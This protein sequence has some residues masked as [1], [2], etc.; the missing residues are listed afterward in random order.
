MVPELGLIILIFAAI[1][2]LSGVIMGFASRSG[3]IVSKHVIAVAL[4]I[5]AAMM[6][7]ALAFWQVDLTVAIVY[8]Q[9]HADL[10]WYYRISA[11]WGGHEGSMLLWVLILCCWS[12]YLLRLTHNSALYLKVGILLNVLLCGLISFVLLT[13]N[14]FARYLPMQPLAGQDLNPLLQDGLMIIHPPILYAGYVGFSMPFIMAV[15][16]LWD[17]IL[18]IDAMRIIRKTALLAFSFLTLGI[19]LGSFWAYYELGWGG[20]WFWDPVEN[21]SMMPWLSGLALIHIVSLSIHRQQYQAWMLFLCILSFA[22]SMLGTFLVRSGIL[23]SVHSF[24][25]DPARGYYILALLSVYIVP[26]L[27]VY[28]SR[29]AALTHRKPYILLSRE[30]LMLINSGLFIAM[31]AT[32][33]LGTLYPLFLE[34]MGMGVISV[35]AP[36]FNAVMV[37]IF[38]IVI[39]MMIFV[40]ITHWGRSLCVKSALVSVCILLII[41]LVLG[42]LLKVSFAT[43]FSVAA[44][45]WVLVYLAIGLK[46]DGI[47]GKPL[48]YW[49]M[50]VA[51]VGVIVFML[52]VAISEQGGISKDLR[53][54]LHDTVMAGDYH[55]TLDALSGV[56][57][58]NFDAM[59]AKMTVTDG[60]FTTILTPQ[61]RFYFARQLFISQTAIH[62][63]VTRDIY[64]ALAQPVGDAWDVRIYIKPF[65]RWIW[66]GGLLV[67]LGS[68]LSF[69][70]KRYLR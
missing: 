64:I 56:K 53:M 41:T 36:Y 46:H 31:T 61:K 16:C 58:E 47:R 26:A 68:F 22:L 28:A 19:T 59:Q 7:L 10:P 9:A 23:T 57:G 60:D 44:A 24:A 32:V 38:F 34:A 69:Y 3:D 67:M 45:V 63:T 6:V 42:Y 52:G 70:D 30:G 14:P 25:A 51:H 11:L 15:A 20:W 37:P 8:A 65:Q 27:Y 4:C 18:S 33:S 50:F 1:L 49:G 43:V 5:F 17:R 13:S 54:R 12:I 29:S 62:G 48:S 35:G 2:S 39:L 40:P 66:A 55:I 21:A